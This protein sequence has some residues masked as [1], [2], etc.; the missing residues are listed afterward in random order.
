M[1]ETDVR[2][3]LYE[4]EIKPILV[5]DPDSFVIDEFQVKQGLCRVDVAIIN[6]KLHGYELKSAS[7]NLKRLPDQQAAYSQ[8]F[9]LVSLVVSSNHIEGALEMIPHWWGVFE[10][11]D[12][13]T[14]SQLRPSRQNPQI[15]PY[16]LS[17]LLWK[18]EVLQILLDRGVRGIKSKPKRVLWALLA[19]Q[20]PI[21]ELRE[22]VRAK[23]RERGNWRAVPPQMLCGG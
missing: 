6:G 1:K 22:V 12:D 16:A 11:A 2:Q 23:L 7:D 13:N 20:F 3:A 14:V 15:D 9:D 10:I 5:D 4:S 18:D 8:V 17:Q 19:E 21:D